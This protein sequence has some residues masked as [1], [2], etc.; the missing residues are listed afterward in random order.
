MISPVFPPHIHVADARPILSV[1]GGMDALEKSNELIQKV[2]NRPAQR[3]YDNEGDFR[4]VVLPGKG[5]AG[6]PGF[7]TATCA[8]DINA[9]SPGAQR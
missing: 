8:E 3:V 7:A 9:H 6:K 5:P 1:L 2:I 4:P